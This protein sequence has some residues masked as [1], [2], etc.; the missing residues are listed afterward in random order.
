[1]Y[2]PM[3]TSRPMYGTLVLGLARLGWY[4]LL[5]WLCRELCSKH[6]A[7]LSPKS[8]NSEKDSWLKLDR[9]CLETYAGVAEST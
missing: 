3:D 4:R 2:F 9:R 7:P 6:G 1:M 8:F 5:F